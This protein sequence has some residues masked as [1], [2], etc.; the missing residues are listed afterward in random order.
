MKGG[1][2]SRRGPIGKFA[3]NKTGG[4]VPGQ[5]NPGAVIREEEANLISPEQAAANG[6]ENQA[7]LQMQVNDTINKITSKIDNLR[8]NLVCYEQKIDLTLKEIPRDIRSVNNSNFNLSSARNQY[9]I[10]GN[11]HPMDYT[12][13]SQLLHQLDKIT[14]KDK[15]SN[16]HSSF[17]GGHFEGMDSPQILPERINNVTSDLLITP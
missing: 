14:N 2:G 7:E 5:S 9:T 13:E 15:Q 3:H 4:A 10:G 16:F 6:G 1:K 11:E 17:R 8:D 12:Y